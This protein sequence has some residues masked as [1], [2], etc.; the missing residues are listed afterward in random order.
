MKSSLAIGVVLCCSA[1]SASTS[2]GQCRAHAGTDRACGMKGHRDVINIGALWFA[3]ASAIS[4]SANPTGENAYTLMA[5]SLRKPAWWDGHGAALGLAA[6][7]PENVVDLTAV[8]SLADPLYLLD[9]LAAAEDLLSGVAAS[10]EDWSN[11]QERR[12]YIH[13]EITLQ[14]LESAMTVPDD[15]IA[16]LLSEVAGNEGAGKVGCVGLEKCN[17]TG[18]R[19]EFASCSIRCAL[20]HVLL[21][22]LRRNLGENPQKPASCLHWVESGKERPSEG[23]EL[24][25][26]G[27]AKA[28]ERKTRFTQQDCHEFRIS[29][30]SMDHFIKSGSSYFRPEGKFSNIFMGD[31]PSEAE[32]V[33]FLQTFAAT[34]G[35]TLVDKFVTSGMCDLRATSDL[36][37][38]LKQAFQH[39]PWDEAQKEKL[40]RLISIKC[41]PYFLEM[42]VCSGVCGLGPDS[43]LVLGLKSASFPWDDTLIHTVQTSCQSWF[44]TRAPRLDALFKHVDTW[45]PGG[46]GPLQPDGIRTFHLGVRLLRVFFMASVRASKLMQIC[47]L[48]M[49]QA[50]REAKKDVIAL[51]NAQESQSA[52]FGLEAVLMRWDQFQANIDIIV[53]IL[54]MDFLRAGC[55]MLAGVIFGYF[56]TCNCCCC[57]CGLGMLPIIIISLLFQ[58]A[59]YAVMLPI[60]LLAFFV[61]LPVHVLFLI[62]DSLPFVGGASRWSR[63]ALVWCVGMGPKEPRKEEV[64]ASLR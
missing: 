20:H 49:N 28:L 10:D 13:V 27:L 55:I 18:S 38:E 37:L 2:D 14:L 19:H 50:I 31:P 15:L 1:I 33:A 32:K 3:V 4:G 59:I 29:D 47:L 64:E 39:V 16:R 60:R 11:L 57:C 36:V 58:F 53:G 8:R 44:A 23:R 7:G 45:K 54:S 6:G 42:A 62:V 12:P 35:P 61:I 21:F 9:Q 43:E 46:P 17:A 25:N 5:S 48:P 30:L 41:V 63:S 56:V 26:P 40:K 51:R 34:A 24:S 52:K 22:G